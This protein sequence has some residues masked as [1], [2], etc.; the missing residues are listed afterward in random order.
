M[1]KNSSIS[2]KKKILCFETKNEKATE[3][4]G[5]KIAGI[6]KKE[7]LSCAVLIGPFGAGKTTLI[8]GIVQ[9]LT[10]RKKVTSP[11]FVIVNE[12]EGRGHRVFHFDFY[13]IKSAQELESFGFR[14]YT[15]KGILLIEWGEVALERIDEKTMKIFLNFSGLNSR[16]IKIILP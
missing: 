6:M 7:G 14:E 1:K 3:K 9:S 11:S 5:E 10:G 16:K 13:R 12:Y 15:E 2:V 4:L 8:R